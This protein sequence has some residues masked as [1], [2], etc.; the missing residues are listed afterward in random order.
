MDSLLF[1]GIGTCTSTG[2]EGGMEL[3]G[4]GIVILGLMAGMAIGMYFRR[5]FFLLPTGLAWFA[6]SVWAFT[7]T[8]GGWDIYRIMAS[9]CMM[10][11]LAGISAPFWLKEKAPIAEASALTQEVDEEDEQAKWRKRQGMRDWLSKKK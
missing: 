5:A 8:A 2:A 4:M 3:L 9:I 11:A 6:L 7:V 1:V 10:F